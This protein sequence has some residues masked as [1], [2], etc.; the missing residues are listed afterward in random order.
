MDDSIRAQLQKMVERGSIEYREK[1]RSLLSGD[2]AWSDD[3][4]SLLVDGFLN[5]PYLTKNE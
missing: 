4:V 5:D 1:A 2:L 3:E